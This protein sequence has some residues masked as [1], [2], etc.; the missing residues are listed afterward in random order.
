MGNKLKKQKKKIEK[1]RRIVERNRDFI[2]SK[3]GVVSFGIGFKHVAGKKTDE[4]CLMIH[5]DNKQKVARKNKIPKTIEGVPTDVREAPVIESVDEVEQ[6]PQPIEAPVALAS[7]AYSEETVDVAPTTSRRDAVAKSEQPVRG[8]TGNGAKQSSKTVQDKGKSGGSSIYPRIPNDHRYEPLVG[9]IPIHNPNTGQ[10]RVG[11]LGAIV[12]DRQTDQPLGLSVA[13][14]IGNQVGNHLDDYK[15]ARIGDPINQPPVPLQDDDDVGTLLKFDEDYDAALFEINKRRC[16]PK[17]IGESDEFEL[18]EPVTAYPGMKVECPSRFAYPKGIVDSVM[19]HLVSTNRYGGW[20]YVETVYIEFDDDSPK[21]KHGDSGSVWVQ[22]NTKQP[23]GLHRGLVRHRFRSGQRGI[24][25]CATSMKQ[26]VKWHAFRFRPAKASLL[27]PEVAEFDTSFVQL[28]K[29][30]LAFCWQPAT[31]Q[32][33]VK[34]FDRDLNKT[35]EKTCK[36]R[37]KTGLACAKRGNEIHAV[38]CGPQKAIRWA[39]TNK[40]DLDLDSAKTLTHYQT[41]HKPALVSFSNQLVMAYTHATRQRVNIVTSRDGKQW[42]NRFEISNAKTK[43]G[44]ALLALRNKIVLCWVNRRDNRLVVAE[45]FRFGRSFN[46]YSRRTLWH[47][48]A[49]GQPALAAGSGKIYLGYLTLRG[50]LRVLEKR[51]RWSWRTKSSDIRIIKSN[52]TLLVVDNEVVACRPD[53]PT[54]PTPTKPTQKK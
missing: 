11:V 41:Q 32:L 9:G 47:Y 31:R 13:H 18:N 29:G 43:H 54:K 3:E 10:D 51:D 27:R 21:T 36:A 24:A 50:E 45:L 15:K 6:A 52:P 20:K 53:P 14:A 19:T 48:Q 33:V 40:T 8:R 37:P 44:P 46:V 16:A 17:M 34:R 5:V 2:L 49:A 38:W 25:A 28:K 42:S 35:V 12:F 26:L 23:V 39:K 30:W 4:L 7:V 1:Y 22:R